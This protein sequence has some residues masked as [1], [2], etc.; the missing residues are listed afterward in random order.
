MCAGESEI[1]LPGCVAAFAFLFGL[2]LL[3]IAFAARKGGEPYL[4]PAIVGAVFVGGV[5]VAVVISAIF[6]S[7]ERQ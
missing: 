6:G 7:R 2:V 4:I 3:A 1:S 5:I